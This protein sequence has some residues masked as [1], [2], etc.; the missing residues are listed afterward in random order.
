MLKELKTRFKKL[1]KFVRNRYFIV[2]FIFIFWLAFFD[3]HSL[4][5]QIKLQATLQELKTKKEFFT[6]E[7]NKDSLK[8][9]EL[10]SDDKNLEKFAREE[11]LMKREDEDVFII[12]K[13]Q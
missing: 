7:I 6:N 8:N 10:S 12:V 4:I 1:P 2:S 11:H 9:R 5:K 3:K 13:N